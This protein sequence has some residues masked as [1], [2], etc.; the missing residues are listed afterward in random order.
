M[1]VGPEVDSVVA[2]RRREEL[3]QGSPTERNLAAREIASLRAPGD[4]APPVGARVSE[5]DAPTS[6]RWL[7]VHRRTRTKCMRVPAGPT[8]LVPQRRRR[9]QIGGWRID[10]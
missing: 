3:R 7:R 5:A 8:K 4:I 9:G 10:P 2:R 1:N 6:Q